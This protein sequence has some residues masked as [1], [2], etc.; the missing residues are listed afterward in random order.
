M[1]YTSLRC[2][3]TYTQS[4]SVSQG[5]NICVFL[6][7]SQHT[8]L[9]LLGRY[10]YLGSRVRPEPIHDIYL[11]HLRPW[12]LRSV[13]TNLQFYQIDG[14]APAHRVAVTHT[15][16]TQL[17]RFL[18]VNLQLSQVAMHIHSTTGGCSRRLGLSNTCYNAFEA[19]PARWLQ[20]GN[21]V[22]SVSRSATWWTVNRHHINV[23]YY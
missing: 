23:S 15:P 17:Y 3:H 10:S 20:L 8:Y 14:S 16:N 12:C 19:E 22:D 5:C 21:H 2:R 11:G 1:I 7:D 6:A 13:H 9:G 4:T 18:L